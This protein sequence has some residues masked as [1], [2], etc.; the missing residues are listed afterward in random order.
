MAS[1]TQQEPAPV[2]APDTGIHGAADWRK[3]LR[4]EFR[5]VGVADVSV[6]LDGPRGKAHFRFDGHGGRI[7]VGLRAALSELRALPSHAGVEAT[8][9]ALRHASQKS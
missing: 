9:A 5:R 3:R 6:Y 7:D 8:L 1:T 2:V 4:R